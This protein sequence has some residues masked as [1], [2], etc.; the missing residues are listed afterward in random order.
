[1]KK[2][3]GTFSRGLEMLRQKMRQK[4]RRKNRSDIIRWTGLVNSRPTFVNYRFSGCGLTA[5]GK[6]GKRKRKTPPKQVGKQRKREGYVARKEKKDKP[7]RRATE[8]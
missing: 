7:E 3:A 8:S 1:M 6:K 2:N 4:R 5:G